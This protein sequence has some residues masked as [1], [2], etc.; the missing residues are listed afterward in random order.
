MC[1]AIEAHEHTL[2]L[3]ETLTKIFRLGEGDLRVTQLLSGLTCT[4][5][6]T[7]DALYKQLGNLCIFHRESAL[8]AG[9]RTDGPVMDVL[10]KTPIL[11]S[12]TEEQY[13]A[14]TVTQ[15]TALEQAL[16][17]QNTAS[18]LRTL[19]SQRDTKISNQQPS[20]PYSGP[21]R[22]GTR[23]RGSRG[24][25]PY[26]RSAQPESALPTTPQGFQLRAGKA[27]KS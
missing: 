14:E 3:L 23:G 17:H 16:A 27:K 8:H 10:R 19:A 25:K 24:L 21:T 12:S 5:Y 4:A 6:P 9:R 22:G 15:V 26:A 11:A 18:A 13:T 7:Q 20:K 1:C 2:R